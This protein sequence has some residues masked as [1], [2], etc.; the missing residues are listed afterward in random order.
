[1]L[2]HAAVQRV[3]DDVNATGAPRAKEPA[4]LRR[5]MARYVAGGALDRRVAAMVEA[6]ENTGGR[7]S[8]Q[9]RLDSITVGSWDAVERR[10]DRATVSFVG[11]ETVSAPRDAGDLLPE[12][13]F[14]REPLPLARISVRLQ[15]QDAMWKLVDYAKD[16]LTPAGPMDEPGSRTIERLPE[17]DVFVNRGLPKEDRSA[18]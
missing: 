4:V 9:A 18:R 8:W 14:S 13:R 12:E 7:A 1:M 3:F 10:G 6:I 17:R 15:R 2:R 5:R 16:W 11:Y